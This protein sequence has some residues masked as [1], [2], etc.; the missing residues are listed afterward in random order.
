MRLR[1]FTTVAIRLIGMMSIFYGLITLIFIAMTFFV[2]SDLGAGGR[3]G[4]S[5]L[6][7]MLML[8]FLLPSLMLILG[9]VL[10]AASGPLADAISKGLEE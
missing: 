4:G 3:F 9:I 10:I 7:S 6:G 8:Q 1:S 5:E 2:F